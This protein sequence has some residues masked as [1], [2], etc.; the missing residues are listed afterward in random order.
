MPPLKQLDVNSVETSPSR[1][2]Q[3]MC[4]V[5][6]WWRELRA[7][8]SRHM[9]VAH[10]NVTIKDDCAGGRREIGRVCGKVARGGQ[11]NTLVTYSE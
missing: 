2:C 8:G 6:N 3:C 5:C 11:Y 9:S 7:Y 1:R 4:P 10:I